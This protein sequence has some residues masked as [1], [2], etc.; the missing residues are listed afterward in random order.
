MVYVY[1]HFAAERVDLPY[2]M[3]FGRAPYI[4]IAGH[5]RYGT[6]NAKYLLHDGSNFAWGTSAKIQDQMEFQ[7]K[8][9]QRIKDHILRHSKL[10]S[11][12]YEAK[13]RIEWYMYADEAKEKGFV[14]YII[15]EDCDIDEVI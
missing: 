14:D 4:G 2:K 3:S 9:E 10:T 15:G 12:E 7:K 11:D 5:K 1:A 13:Y 6:K 8:V